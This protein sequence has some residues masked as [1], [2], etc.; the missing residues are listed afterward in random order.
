MTEKKK[1]LKRI[2]KH[3]V[4]KKLKKLEKNRKENSEKNNKLFM[5]GRNVP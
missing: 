3:Y 1:E 2:R 5:E 4:S